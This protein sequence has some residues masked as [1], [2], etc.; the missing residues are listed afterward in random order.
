MSDRT[1]IATASVVYPRRLLPFWSDKRACYLWQLEKYI[2]NCPNPYWMGEDVFG[3]IS[4]AM[5]IAKH[6]GIDIPEVPSV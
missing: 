6:Y 5:A 4:W 2:S 1:L 3:D